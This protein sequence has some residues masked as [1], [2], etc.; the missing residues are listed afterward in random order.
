MLRTDICRK[1]PLLDMLWPAIVGLE[2]QA[3]RTLKETQQRG[4][5]WEHNKR[6]TRYR[7]TI[8]IICVYV[9]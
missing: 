9:H 3:E 6:K 8:Q 1:A 4:V 5:E 2:P 7:G